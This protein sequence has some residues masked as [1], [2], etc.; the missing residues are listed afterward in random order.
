MAD[1]R[2]KLRRVV[3]FTKNNHRWSTTF[4]ESDLRKEEEPKNK[5]GEKVEIDKNDISDHG[6]Q[7]MP[8]KRS[9]TIT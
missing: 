8:L 5:D 2:P 9:E 4:D 3:T 1:V 6:S 7:N